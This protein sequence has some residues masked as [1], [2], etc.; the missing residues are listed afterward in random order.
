M[1]S[2]KQELFRE[3]LAGAWSFPPLVPLAVLA[4][5]CEKAEIKELALKLRS[6]LGNEKITG[7]AWTKSAFPQGAAYTGAAV[8][9]AKVPDAAPLPALWGIRLDMPLPASIVE[10]KKN[11]LPFD[12]PVLV[13]ALL[14]RSA[15]AP[16][17][18]PLPEGISFRAAALAA[19]LLT[20]LDDAPKNNAPR[21]DFMDRENESLS[22]AWEL[23]E[24]VWLPNP[25][26]RGR[27]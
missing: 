11:A 15:D 26:R 27:D 21:D 10:G 5:R 13:S 2:V 23:D 18:R 25:K 16:R 17:Q 22:F 9:D 24:P 1:L 4:R 20:P 7:A 19:M 6:M 12:S 8:P 14:R 3:G